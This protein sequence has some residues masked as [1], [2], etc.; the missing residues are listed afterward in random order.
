MIFFL[1]TELALIFSPLRLSRLQKG[2]I[3]MLITQGV[4]LSYGNK[5]L[6]KDVEG[7]VSKWEHLRPHWSKWGGQIDFPQI[8]A[9][10]IQPDHGEVSLPSGARLAVLRQINL[11][12]TRS[13]S[14][15]P[16]SWSQGAL[17]TY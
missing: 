11:S 10:E 17:W 2:R 5:S 3:S 6:F 4:S 13:L 9:G 12:L 7:K 1:L 16:Y 8:L 14:S 15:K